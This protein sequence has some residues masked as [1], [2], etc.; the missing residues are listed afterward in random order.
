MSTLALTDLDVLLNM[1]AK[2]EDEYGY[3]AAP[4]DLRILTAANARRQV[5]GHEALT[6]RNLIYHGGDKY[7]ANARWHWRLTEAGATYVQRL[8][9]SSDG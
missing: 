4:G 2:C 8:R 6:V 3:V 5:A 9:E 1:I 7:G